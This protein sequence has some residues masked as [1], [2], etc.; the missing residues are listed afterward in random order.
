[1][2]QIPFTHIIPYST[3]KNLG[4][5]A[6]AMISEIPDPERWVLMT[7]A[8]VMMLTPNYGHI[9]QKVIR[10]YPDTG[11]FTCVTN[12]VKNHQQLIN[13]HINEDPNMRTHRRTAKE[14]YYEYGTSCITLKEH[15]SGFFML[16]K[17][18]TWQKV[19][20]FHKKGILRV[21]NIFSQAILDAGYK[22]RLIQGIYA[23]HYYRMNET[24]IHTHHL[25]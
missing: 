19:G 11:L 7:D 18:A 15:I 9:I 3:E 4:A 2:G 24:I 20:G 21:D 23:L 1:M 17:K 14:R 5:A 8:D 6:N 10:D 22:I 13:G 12:R 25:L 16:F